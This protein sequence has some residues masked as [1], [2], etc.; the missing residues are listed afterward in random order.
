M[1]NKQLAAK[2]KKLGMPATMI[3]RVQAQPD[4]ARTT[5]QRRTDATARRQGWDGV[6]GSSSH[7]TSGRYDEE[8]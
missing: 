4:D 6:E 5:E 2:M 1:T 3:A 7:Y 8:S